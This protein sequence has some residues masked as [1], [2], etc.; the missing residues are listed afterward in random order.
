MACANNSRCTHQGTW[1]S[2]QS[3]SSSDAALSSCL[4]SVSSVT[5]KT[6]LKPSAGTWADLGSWFKSRSRY[7]AVLL[8]NKSLSFCR[9]SRLSY[10]LLAPSI[11]ATIV[12][13]FFFRVCSYSRLLLTLN[14]HFMWILDWFSWHL[15]FPSF[16]GSGVLFNF[17][18]TLRSGAI[19]Q[20][21]NK[22]T[23]MYGNPISPNWNDREHHV[24]RESATEHE[25]ST[26]S[27]ARIAY[28][29]AKPPLP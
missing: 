28:L 27:G 22:I 2:S 16:S 7:P 11:R 9:F 12:L 10:F 6:N 3:F 20:D 14:F 21:F 8:S 26:S 1:S 29:R 13:V 19:F 24:L 5:A 4:S 23:T 25:C 17:N 18:L 15:I